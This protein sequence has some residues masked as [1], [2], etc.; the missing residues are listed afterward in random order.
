MEGNALEENT[1]HANKTGRFFTCPHGSST[2][3]NTHMHTPTQTHTHTHTHTRKDNGCVSFRDRFSLRAS[4]RKMLT[5]SF[6]LPPLF[7]SVVGNNQKGG[8]RWKQIP[9]QT[10]TES[11]AG[12]LWIIWWLQSCDE[13]LSSIKST[14]L[15]AYFTFTPQ[16]LEGDD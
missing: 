14:A 16:M 10:G 11:T 13:A 1:L 3:G 12:A 2:A 4:D 5:G 9:S 15:G 7:V 6:R 8:R